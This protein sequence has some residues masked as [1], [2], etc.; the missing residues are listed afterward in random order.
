M[1]HTALRVH[2]TIYVQDGQ[3]AFSTALLRR[4]HSNCMAIG[5]IRS[6]RLLDTSA[7]ALA[8]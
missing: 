6:L 7:L 5:A 4:A 3:S 1:P 2:G 8:E